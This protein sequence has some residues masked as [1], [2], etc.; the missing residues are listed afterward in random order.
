MN[1]YRSALHNAYPNSKQS[2]AVE[3]SRSIDGGYGTKHL[4]QNLLHVSVGPLH[5]KSHVP[6]HC[7]FVLSW[8]NTQ[9]SIY[10]TSTEPVRT[11]AF[12]LNGTFNMDGSRLR[13][14]EEE[15]TLKQ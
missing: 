8:A 2:C 11:V 9:I 6:R 4:R 10:Y 7:L 15:A 13:L 14:W 1:P 12:P 5:M 3:E